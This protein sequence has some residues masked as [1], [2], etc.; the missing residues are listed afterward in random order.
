MNREH[1][2]TVLKFVKANPSNIRMDD[3]LAYDDHQ[4]QTTACIAGSIA[5]I[6]RG[7]TF[8]NWKECESLRV[9]FIQVGADYLGLTIEQAITIFFK[10]NWPFEALRLPTY[11]GI[12]YMLEGILNDTLVYSDIARMWLPAARA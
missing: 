1:F 5:M 6:E 10:H 7:L 8:D 9:D 12:I 4:C 3:W 2:E 11:E